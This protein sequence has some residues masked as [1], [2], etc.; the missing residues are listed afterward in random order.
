[1]RNE[2]S[3][4]LAHHVQPEWLTSGVHHSALVLLCECMMCKTIPC[5][6]QVCSDRWA[7]QNTVKGCFGRTAAAKYT[8][9]T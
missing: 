1:M 9:R 8:I 7:S 4:I 5:D 2:S 3:A 6:Q